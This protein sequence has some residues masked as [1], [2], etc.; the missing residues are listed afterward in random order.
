MFFELRSI[1]WFQ[2]LSMTCGQMLKHQVWRRTGSVKEENLYLVH[3]LCWF[4]SWACLLSTVLSEL[5]ILSQILTGHLNY[6]WMKVLSFWIWMGEFV[7]LWIFRTDY[8][9]HSG[10]G[11]QYFISRTTWIVAF[12]AHNRQDVRKTW[13]VIPMESFS[14]DNYISPLGKS[15]AGFEKLCRWTCC[16]LLFIFS[17]WSCNLYVVMGEGNQSCAELNRLIGIF[18]LTM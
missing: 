14:K 8:D 7:W 5:G 13:T 9:S 3:R 18:V 10:S 16:I 2:P 11:G 17:P 1:R 15:H 6:S 12:S 4:R